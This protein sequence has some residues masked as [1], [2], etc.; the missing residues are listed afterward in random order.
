MEK[1]MNVG[2]GVVVAG[3]IILFIVLIMVLNSMY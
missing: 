1:F 2:L 3:F